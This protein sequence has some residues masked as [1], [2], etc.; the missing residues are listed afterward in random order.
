M[1][2]QTFLRT[3]LVSKLRATGTLNPSSGL[4]PPSPQREKGRH[5][6]KPERTSMNTKPITPATLASSV[7]SVPPLARNADGAFNRDENRKIIRH[8]EAGGVTT[9]LYGGN[10][11]LAHVA[12]SEYAELRSMLSELAGEQSLVIPSVGPGF[13]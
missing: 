3:S 11:I 6:I 8:L 1:R 10:A 7:I 5:E 2:I 9:L 4:R 12:I 13:G